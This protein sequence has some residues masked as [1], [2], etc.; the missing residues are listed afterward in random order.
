LID[1]FWEVLREMAAADRRL[2]LAFVTGSDR[3][4]TFI[5]SRMRLKLMLLGA[6][7]RRFPIAHTCFNQLGLWLYRSKAEL[8]GKLLVA[9]KESEGFGLK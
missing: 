2:F 6:D 4:P 3:M 5:S 1:W 7:Y 8:R 9:I